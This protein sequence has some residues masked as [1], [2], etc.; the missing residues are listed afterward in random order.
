MVV[1]VSISVCISARGGVTP[2]LERS[3][4]N[5]WTVREL[6]TKEDILGSLRDLLAIEGGYRTIFNKNKH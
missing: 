2:K 4:V 3:R 6:P 5:L 1:N